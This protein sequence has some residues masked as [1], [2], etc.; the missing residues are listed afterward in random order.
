VRD[1]YAARD[2]IA[3]K[4]LSRRIQKTIVARGRTIYG[5]GIPPPTSREPN[6]DVVWELLQHSSDGWGTY[7]LAEGPKWLPEV[8][9]GAVIWTAWVIFGQPRE[10][11]RG[12][13]RPVPTPPPRV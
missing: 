3:G 6:D 1:S 11:R 10:A 7:G 2:T 9:S 5:P 12:R 8:I 4:M 13:G